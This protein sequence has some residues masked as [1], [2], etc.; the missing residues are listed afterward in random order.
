M[1]AVTEKSSKIRECRNKMSSVNLGS[2]GLLVSLVVEAHEDLLLRKH[3]HRGEHRAG[4][5]SGSDPRK[6]AIWAGRSRLQV[7]ERI[8]EGFKEYNSPA[9]TVS[10]RGVTETLLSTRCRD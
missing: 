7:S 2:W 4:R 5:H 8:H 1:T 3:R 9:D 6:P 10:H